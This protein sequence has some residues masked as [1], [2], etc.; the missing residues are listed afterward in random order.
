MT[1]F[2]KNFEE[3]EQLRE[4]HVLWE[5]DKEKT[6]YKSAMEKIQGKKLMQEV[7]NER[8]RRTNM[9]FALNSNIMEKAMDPMNITRG[10]GSSFKKLPT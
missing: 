2:N 8:L 3:K 9:G 5:M 7:E 10:S 1:Y 4:T 6:Y